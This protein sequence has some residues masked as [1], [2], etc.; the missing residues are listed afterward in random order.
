MRKFVRKIIILYRS[1]SSRS[2]G[3][4]EGRGG[5]IVD[6][7]PFQFAFFSRLD[8]ANKYFISEYLDQ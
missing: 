5:S 1:F 3:K 7:S 4:R 2:R 8:L 6:F